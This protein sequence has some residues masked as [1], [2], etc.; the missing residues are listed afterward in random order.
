[1]GEKMAKQLTARIGVKIAP[2]ELGIVRWHAR[3]YDATDAEVGRYAVLRQAGYGHDEARSM[4]ITRNYD[5]RT[6]DMVKVFEMDPAWI[7]AAMKNVPEAARVNTSTM[8]R[9]SIMS[10]TTPEHEAVE[11]ASRRIGRKP[12]SEKESG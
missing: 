8:F 11:L 1:M 3:L 4:A 12:K 10:I 6:N 9:Y 5:M 7:D 2:R